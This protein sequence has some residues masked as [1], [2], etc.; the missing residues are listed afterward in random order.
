MYFTVYVL[1]S[2]I[3]LESF[4][5][6]VKINKFVVSYFVNQYTLILTMMLIQPCSTTFITD[7]SGSREWCRRYSGFLPPPLG[8]G[9]WR[10][11]RGRRE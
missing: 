11:A 2:S 4:Y 1:N 3:D 7:S 8:P 5:E 9:V 10:L 6:T